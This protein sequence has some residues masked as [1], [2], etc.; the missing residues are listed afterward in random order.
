MIGRAP[1]IFSVPL[2]LGGQQSSAVIAAAFR[3]GCAGLEPQP[4]RPGSVEGE[5]VLV[6]DHPVEEERQRLLRLAGVQEARREA[7]SRRRFIDEGDQKSVKRGGVMI[8]HYVL[9]VR[10]H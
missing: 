4:L 9:V 7:R 3:V 6:L 2:R 8:S 10:T 5:Q 1:I